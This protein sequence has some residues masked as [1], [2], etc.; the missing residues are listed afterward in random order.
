[1]ICFVISGCTG[2]TLGP[3]VK[4]EY[5]IMNPGR[6]AQIL[7]N[8]NVVVKPLDGQGNPVVQDVG[9]WVVM[10]ETHWSALKAAFEEKQKGK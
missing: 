1:M 9:G 10:P 4:T 6:P 7:E 3:Q 5:V 2:L 8:K